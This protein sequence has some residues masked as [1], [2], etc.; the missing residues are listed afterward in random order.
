M[1]FSVSVIVVMG[2]VVPGVLVAMVMLGRRGLFRW[3]TCQP[4]MLVDSHFVSTRTLAAVRIVFALFNITAIIY[5]LIND[6]GQLYA[7]YVRFFVG[8]LLS[9]R[10]L[11]FL[12]RPTGT[13][14]SSRSRSACFPFCLCTRYVAHRLM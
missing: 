10:I 1:Q 5:A 8:I 9:D 11:D 3:S 7:T 14:R 13:T 6:G 4:D 12:P 2:L